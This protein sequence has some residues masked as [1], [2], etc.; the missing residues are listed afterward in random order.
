MSTKQNE[1]SPIVQQVGMLNLRI[2]DMM[3]QLNI[4][5][6]AMM[7]ENVALKKENVELKVKIEKSSKS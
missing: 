6:K 4:V 5:M 3:A 2:N 7:E 1:V